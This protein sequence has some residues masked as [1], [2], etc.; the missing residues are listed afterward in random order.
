MWE[1]STPV[2]TAKEQL[3]KGTTLTYCLDAPTDTTAIW[4]SALINSTKVTS[5]HRT[6]QHSERIRWPL[7]ED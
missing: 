2:S 4:S 5:D 3:I 7:P 6:W 1:M